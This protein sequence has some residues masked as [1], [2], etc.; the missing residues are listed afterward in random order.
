VYFR[1][2]ALGAPRVF[3]GAC[4]TVAG[5]DMYAVCLTAN[6]RQVL[7][8]GLAQL[9]QIGAGGTASAFAAP[10]RDQIVKLTTDPSDVAALL[11]VQGSPYVVRVDRAYTMAQGAAPNWSTTRRSA[12]YAIVAE[13]VQPLDP[14]TD[15][16]K[17]PVYAARKVVGV[18]G[19]G[20][21]ALCT[22][23]QANPS[24]ANVKLCNDIVDAIEDFARRGVDWHD[25]H[26][27]NIGHDAKGQLKVLDAG[28]TKSE[29]VE[30][31]TLLEGARRRRR[32]RR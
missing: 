24:A 1:A 16:P 25:I 5:G 18:A 7:F 31:P 19:R 15:R 3:D 27:G 28:A 29:L 8:G 4:I 22:T 14:K 11:K 26:A 13:R 17:G 9:V 32:S 12:L 2:G 20:N 6:Q 30:M 23:R 21:R 10:R